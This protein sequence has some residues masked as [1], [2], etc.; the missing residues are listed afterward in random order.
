MNCF[1]CSGLFLGDQKT[2]DLL[3]KKRKVFK[4]NKSLRVNMKVIC[5]GNPRQ[6]P[7]TLRCGITKIIHE[8]L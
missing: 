7:E 1:L 8:S 5:H 4:Q 6:V 3:K 2:A